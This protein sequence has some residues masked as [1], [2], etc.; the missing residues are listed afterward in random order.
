MNTLDHVQPERLH[1]FAYW[2]QQGNDEFSVGYAVPKDF[3]IYRGVG[4]ILI[5]LSGLFNLFL[6]PKIRSLPLLLRMGPFPAMS[7]LIVLLTTQR[8][9]SSGFYQL[10]AEGNPTAFIGT[11]PPANILD[12]T[13]IK[14][15]KF[16]Q[17]L[18][19]GAA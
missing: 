7:L 2:P 5:L 11:Q 17:T 1:I 9:T 4:I 13:G 6:A 12:R 8:I 3:L 16:L 14:R 18:S 10:D 15:K 19:A